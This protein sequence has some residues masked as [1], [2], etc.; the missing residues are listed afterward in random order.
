M[1]LCFQII[2]IGSIQLSLLNKHTEVILYD[3]DEADTK[4]VCAKNITSSNIECLYV[5][6]E[7][8]EEELSL[9]YEYTPSFYV[10]QGIVLSIETDPSNS[11]DC[12]FISFANEIL[13]CCGGTNSVKCTRFDNN[14]LFIIS[15]YI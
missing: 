12:T 14:Y 3:T 10:S 4:M 7:I 13:Y 1:Q 2:S 9:Q 5:R 15:F 11:E 8:E 6:C